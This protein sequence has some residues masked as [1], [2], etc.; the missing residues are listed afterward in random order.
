MNKNILLLSNAYFPSIGGIEN[1]LRHLAQEALLAGDKVEIIVSDIGLDEHQ[2][3]FSTETVDEVL[4]T[5]YPLRP[6]NV[7][8]MSILNTLY[9]NFILYKLL[10]EKHKFSPGSIVIA[11]FHFAAL[12]ANL[13]GFKQVRYLVPSV[14]SQ[15]IVYENQ[16]SISL[17]M[18]LRNKLKS[19]LHSSVQRMALVRSDVFVFSDTMKQQCTLLVG[20]NS[21]EYSIVKP[22]V[23]S[24]RFSPA[25]EQERQNLKLQLDLPTDKPLVLFVG[26]F[27]K[28]KGVELL[29]N[30]ISKVGQPCHLILIGAGEELT[31]Y[32]HKIA[33]LGLN[34]DVTIIR[35][36][37]KVEN[38]YRCADIFIM[39]SSYEPLGQTILEAFASGLPVVAFK[40]SK[41]VDTATQELGMD[42]FI[43]YANSHTDD[44]LAKAIEEQLQR[45]LTLNRQ[46][47]SDKACSSFSWKKL[48]NDL[49]E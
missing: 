41:T 33:S 10:R 18:R 16:G 42:E 20:D 36:L 43:T 9:S 7:K 13:V 25:G 48:Y 29:I 37:K 46:S 44:C 28:A 5:R 34:A 31:S 11:R 8:F 38:Y 47:I 45:N 17:I 2:C 4:V 23:D 24:V 19:L 21:V 26:R 3:G 49:L 39:S 1:S 12:I 15:Q 6:I 30:A 35:P 40:K 22:G 32:E 27:V 14:F